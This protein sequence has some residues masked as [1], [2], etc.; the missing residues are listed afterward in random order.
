MRQVHHHP[1][2]IHASDHT[3]AKFVKSFS[4][5]QSGRMKHLILCGTC[6]RNAVV[7]GEGQVTR[8]PCVQTIQASQVFFD[9][10]SPFNSNDRRQLFLFHDPLKFCV[11]S[12]EHTSE[13]Q[14]LMRISY[15]AFCSNKNNIHAPNIN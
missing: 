7:P 13:L 2:F 10:V 1:Q 5:W 4:V 3:A 6:P 9:H 15:A 11:R 14:S 12:E 8:S